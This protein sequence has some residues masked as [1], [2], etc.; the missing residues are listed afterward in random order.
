MVNIDEE[1]NFI[2][3]RP[4]YPNGPNN[5]LSSYAYGREVFHGTIKE[6]IEMRD[7]IRGRANEYSDEYEIYP[8]SNEPLKY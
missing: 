1:F 4:W 5:S 3:A 2:I 7:F 6:A 8:I